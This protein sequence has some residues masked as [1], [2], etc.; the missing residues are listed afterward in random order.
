MS[1]TRSAPR[2]VMTASF[3]VLVVAILLQAAT[4]ANT[5]NAFSDSAERARFLAPLA[6]LRKGERR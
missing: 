1:T 5:M 4:E 3:T 6:S 2:L